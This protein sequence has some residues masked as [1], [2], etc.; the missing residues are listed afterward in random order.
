MTVHESDTDSV[1]VGCM[2]SVSVGCMDSVSVGCMDSVS[3]GCMD[4]VSVGGMDAI[5]IGELDPATGGASVRWVGTFSAS[6]FLFRA[7]VRPYTTLMV[8]HSTHTL[9]SVY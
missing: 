8:S 9:N 2:D 7:S 1:S 4:S 6:L 3:V 5:P